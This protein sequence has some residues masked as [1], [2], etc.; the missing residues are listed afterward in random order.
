MN[1]FSTVHSEMPV[2][3]VSSSITILSEATCQARRI[4]ILLL[5]KLQLAAISLAHCCGSGSQHVCRLL[6]AA[7]GPWPGEPAVVACWAVHAGPVVSLLA[8]HAGCMDVLLV[9]KWCMAIREGGPTLS[10]KHLILMK[11]VC[12]TCGNCG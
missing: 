9:N 3:E 7:A 10:E 11:A 8:D 5:M 6:A 2:G 4:A 12:L 1:L